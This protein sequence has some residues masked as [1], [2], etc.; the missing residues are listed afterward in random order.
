MTTFG[1]SVYQMGGV[2]VGLGNSVPANNVYWVSSVVGN[3]SNT[4]K[5]RSAPLAT[6]AAALAKCT[7]N[8]GDI[9]YLMPGHAENVAS[10]AAIACNVAGVIT[11]GLGM[12]SLR[13]KFSFTAAAATFTI[14]A[15]NLYFENICWEANFA[16]VAVGLNISAVNHLHFENCRWTEAGTDLNF[17]TPINAA[18]GG[19]NFTFNQCKVIT[20]DAANT[21]HMAFVAHD[22]LYIFD[23]Y[24]AANVAQGGGAAGLLY[25]SGNVTNVD[26]KRCSFRSNIDGAMFIDFNGAAC[27]GLITFC[28]FSSIDT[29]GAVTACI[30]FTGGHVFEC[31]VAGDADS[32]GLVGGGTV[33]SN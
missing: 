26:I 13:P 29:A 28:M 2:P 10:A 20:G 21:Y 3:D 6:F 8:K 30:D 4:G 5:K 11:I 15:S 1:D 24:F 16:D 17:I 18:T 22:G 14:T 31:Y 23:S 7:A 32:F 19:T 25:S 12:G 9:I 27:G 33:Y